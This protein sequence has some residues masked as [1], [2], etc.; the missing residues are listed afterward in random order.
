MKFAR[1]QAGSETKK[2]SRPL[3]KQFSTTIAIGM[4]SKCHNQKLDSKGNGNGLLR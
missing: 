1:S 3:V 2:G 4:K